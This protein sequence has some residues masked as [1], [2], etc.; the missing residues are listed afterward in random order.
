MIISEKELYELDNIIKIQCSDGNYNY[1]S[2]MYGLA[3]GLIL[4][5]SLITGI[6]LKFMDCPDSWL[7]EKN[8]CE[9]EV[10]EQDSK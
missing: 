7:E 9:E 8:C 1:N 4:A 5:R 3:N 2:Y 6:E 10:M